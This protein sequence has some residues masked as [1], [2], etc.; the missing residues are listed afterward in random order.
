LLG[1]LLLGLL[2]NWGSGL[3]GTAWQ[4]A[5]AFVLLVLILLFRPTGLLGESLGRARA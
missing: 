4:H 3:F 1:G 5:V 2:E